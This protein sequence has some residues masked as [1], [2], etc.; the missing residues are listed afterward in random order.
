LHHKQAARH[1]ARRSAL[2]GD[3]AALLHI[4]LASSTA[5]GG[6]LA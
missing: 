2:H 3:A 6:E 4:E 5:P 1:H